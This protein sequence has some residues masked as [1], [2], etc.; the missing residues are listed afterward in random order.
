MPNKRKYFGELLRELRHTKKWSQEDLA[1][2]LDVSRQTIANTERGQNV[3]KV[4]FVEHVFR[5]FES[6]EIV[7]AY[8][9]IQDDKRELIAL[10]NFVAEVDYSVAKQIMKKVIRGSLKTNDFETMFPAMFQI[11]M[12]DMKIKKKV[13]PKKSSWLIRI[14]ENLG[15]DPDLFIE[16]T[17]ELYAI[18]GSSKNYEA[19]ITITEAIKDKVYLDNRKLS[20]MLGH[21][22]NAYY[23]TGD[24]HKAYK[25]MSKAIEVMNGE[26]YKH[27]HFIY[28]KHAMICLQKFNYDEALECELKCLE[29]LEPTSDFLKFINAGLARLYYMT[30]RYEDAQIYWES[31]FKRLGKNDP[32]R[33]HSL[34]DIIM[35]EIRLGNLESARVK[36]KECDEILKLARKSDWR[37]YDDEDML[38]RRNKVMLKAVETGEYVTREVDNILQEL[39]KSHLKDELLLTKNFVLER[40]LLSVRI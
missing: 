10:A 34:N 15:P 38:L 12:W 18:S 4:R 28:H 1:E 40:A 31:A 3:P 6:V 22:A 7:K 19:F 16:L 30:G 35:M 9:A 33:T 21:Q 17:D 27:T 14:A 20:Y 29:I 39:E 13:N 2:V 23:Y 24:E 37:H 25:K 26:V 32:E 5:L 8:A 11:V 36:I